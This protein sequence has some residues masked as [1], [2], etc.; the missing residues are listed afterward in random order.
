MGEFL[1]GF[2]VAI[3]GIADDGVVD[4]LEMDADLV[5]A[6]G[7]D[8][9][10]EVGG[11]GEGWASFDKLRMTDGGVVFF[12]LIVRKREFGFGTVGDAGFL[13]SFEERSFDG[14]FFGGEVAFD[15][16][17]VGFFDLAVAKHVGE[18][19]VGLIGFGDDDEAGGVFI[20]AMDDARAMRIDLAEV[21]VETRD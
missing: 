16:G 6:A 8:L 12:N 17:E 7:D 19:S 3:G 21:L 15:Q 18:K 13:G 2:W 11:F 1:I 9:S 10:F 5:G 4:A 20:E 14:A